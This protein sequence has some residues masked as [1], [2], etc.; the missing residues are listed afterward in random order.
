MQFDSA[1]IGLADRVSLR[2]SSSFCRSETS[3]QF[4]V[5]VNADGLSRSAIVIEPA[6]NV[7]Q[8]NYIGQLEER[9]ATI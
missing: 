1:A 7:Y 6:I 8:L 9:F 2:K 3:L 4:A 5:T